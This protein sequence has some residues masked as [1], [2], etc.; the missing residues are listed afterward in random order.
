MRTEITLLG[1]RFNTAAQTRRRCLVALFYGSFAALMIISWIAD[2]SGHAA[3]FWGIEFTIF[4]AP[5]LGGYFS[6]L[7]VRSFSPGI[8]N[9]FDGNETIRMSSSLPGFLRR[10]YPDP[11]AIHNDERELNQRDHAH[12]RAYRALSVIVALAFL[13]EFDEAGKLPLLRT[14]GISYHA[15]QSAIFALLQIGY[16]LAFTLPAAIILWTEPDLEPQSPSAEIP[17]GATP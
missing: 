11:R 2:A 13:L 12:Y 8:V 6:G 9:P 5:I 3:G 4:V 7:G 14:I 16:L 15:V 10:L 17:S 1:W